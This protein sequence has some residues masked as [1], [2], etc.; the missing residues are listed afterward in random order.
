MKLFPPLRAT[1]AAPR[2]QLR[3]S[4]FILSRAGEIRPALQLQVK[5]SLQAH[6]HLHRWAHQDTNHPP[7]IFCL[8]RKGITG[9]VLNI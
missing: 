5:L 1:R 6:L 4:L 2:R 7:I 9:E 8:I 3:R